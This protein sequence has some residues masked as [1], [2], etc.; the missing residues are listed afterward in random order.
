MNFNNFSQGALL[1]TET[2]PILVPCPPRP[3]SQRKQPQEKSRHPKKIATLI[4]KKTT[5]KTLGQ[6]KTTKKKTTRRSPPK[7]PPQ[8]LQPVLEPVA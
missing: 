6:E 8:V 1:R 2:F 5:R 3:P 7:T 4:R